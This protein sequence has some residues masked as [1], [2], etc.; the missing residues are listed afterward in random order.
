[1]LPSSAL[2]MVDSLPL[3]L[4]EDNSEKDKNDFC[5][6]IIEGH[7]NFVQLYFEIE[8]TFSYWEIYTVQLAFHYF[9][10]LV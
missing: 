7:S 3:E 8:K 10:K 1:M 4:L 9:M 5:K 2:F 6:K